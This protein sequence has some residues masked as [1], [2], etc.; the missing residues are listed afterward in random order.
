[1]LAVT[2]GCAG[3]GGGLN[4]AVSQFEAGQYPAAKQDLVSLEGKEARWSMSGRAQYALY[5]GLT[6]GALGDE[7]Q[8]AVWLEKAAAVEAAHPGA[9]SGVDARRLNL[10]KAALPALPQES[11]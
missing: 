10:V 4:D 6:L 5:R 1:M 3:C 9:L 7:A 8:A 2:L 11:P